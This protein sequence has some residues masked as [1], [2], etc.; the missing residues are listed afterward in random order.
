MLKII[1][2]KVIKWKQLWRTIWFNTANIEYFWDDIE[3]WVYKINI[4]VEK[5][6]YHWAGSF[7]K[8]IN[9]FESHIFDF[10]KD[11]Y[12]KKIEIVILEKIRENQ[13]IEKLEQLK[14]LIK[15]D[16]EK[17]KS[18]KNNVLTFWTFDLV[19]EWHKY[20]LN[21]SKKYWDKLITIL[22]TDNNIKKFKWKK[23]YFDKKERIKHIKELNISD[24]VIWWDE[25]NPLKWLNIYL[26]KIICLWYDQIWFSENLKKHIKENNLDIKI[27]KIKSYKKEIFKSSIIKKG[28]YQLK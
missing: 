23:P 22:A 19:H 20:F 16:I 24:I 21:Q 28:Y 5:K 18:S 2:W 10:N 13:K 1:K 4:I 8:N 3:D 17:I 14:N 9:I 11:I 25:N 26:P 27:I 6:V 7:R 15:N 12:G